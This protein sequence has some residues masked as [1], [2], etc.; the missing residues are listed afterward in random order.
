VVR[1]KSKSSKEKTGD[2]VARLTLMQ[3]RQRLTTEFDAVDVA[4]GEDGFIVV[5]MRNA[6]GD[7]VIVEFARA[8]AKKLV[9]WR[10]LTGL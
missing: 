3:G 4:P 9:S 8:H 5:T 6:S 2:V 7:E 1:S 10:L